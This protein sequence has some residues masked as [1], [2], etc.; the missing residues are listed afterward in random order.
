MAYSTDFGTTWSAPVEIA[1]PSNA[2][3]LWPWAVA[4]DAGKLSIVWYQ[5]DK[6]IDPDCEVSNVS[7][8]ESR[9]ENATDPA[10]R[11]IETVQAGGR[12]IH[13]NGVCQGGTLCV[14]SG[15]DRRLGDFFTNALDSR[16]CVMIASADTTQPDPNTGG[17][18]ATSLPVI[19]RQSSGNP[20]QGSGTCGTTTGQPGGPPVRATNT[21]RPTCRDRTAPTST[22]KLP[23]G[24]ARRGNR[25]RFRGRSKDRGCRAANGLFAAAGK[26]RRVYVSLAKVGRHKCSFINRKGKLTRRR[27]CRKAIFLRARGTTRW[28]FGIKVH[29]P[30]GNYRA[31]VRAVDASGNKETPSARRDIIRFRLPRL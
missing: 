29:V 7:I 9:V 3:V 13:Q 16:G 12:P 30:P 1:G 2:R 21:G 26:V 27:S 28:T 31:V 19:L 8:Y 23:R 17:P 22:L 14:A 4:G 15:K 10:T 18:M 25:L 5:T 20:L 6:L 24:Y 11:T